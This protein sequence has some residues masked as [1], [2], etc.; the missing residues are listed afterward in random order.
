[1]TWPRIALLLPALGFL[2]FGVAYT[3]WPLPMARMTDITLPTPNARIDFA[4][5]SGGVQLALGVFFFIASR[6]PAWL[7]PGLWAAAAV[8]GGLVLVRLPSMLAIGEKPTRVIFIALAI[9]IIGFLICGHA[10][11]TVRRAGAQP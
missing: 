5:I 6:R 9:E 2:G 3:L 10:L 4:A 11:R 8:F 7:E 1:M